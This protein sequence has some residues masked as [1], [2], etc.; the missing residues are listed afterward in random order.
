MKEEVQTSAF[1]TLF[2]S[3]AVLDDDRYLSF[4]SQVKI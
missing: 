3:L 2:L 1:L 4:E